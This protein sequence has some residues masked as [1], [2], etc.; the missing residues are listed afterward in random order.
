[1]I[2]GHDNACTPNVSKNY[3]LYNDHHS[4]CLKVSL[5]NT[6]CIQSASN[7]VANFHQCTVLQSNVKKQTSELGTSYAS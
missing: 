3:T 5:W 4:V 7:K 2:S 1:M 6:V